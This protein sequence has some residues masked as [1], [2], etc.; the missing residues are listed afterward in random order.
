MSSNSGDTA[1]ARFNNFCQYLKITPDQPEV[2]CSG[3]AHQL[4]YTYKIKIGGV[5]Y[6][7]GTGPSQS[8]AKEAAAAQAIE[9][10]HQQ[11]NGAYR[12]YF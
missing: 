5:V 12:G 3:P 2:S 4:T 11:Y 8:A 9:Q 6:G 10:L 7:T 1:R